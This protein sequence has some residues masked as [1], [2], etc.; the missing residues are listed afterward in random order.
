MA[1]V[2]FCYVSQDKELAHELASALQKMGLETVDAVLRLGDS[3]SQ[4]VEQGLRDADY[5]VI[6]LS[7]AFF[8]KPW[9]RQELD[10]LTRIEREYEGHTQL[11][12]IWHE[13]AQQDIARFSPTLASKVG[14][15]TSH[16]VA[17]VAEE[18]ADV[19]RAKQSSASSGMTKGYPSPPITKGG[20]MT[21]AAGVDLK[22]LLQILQENFSE[23]ELRL[24]CFELAIDYEDLPGSGKKRKSLE[25]ISY[26]Q[27]HAKL[28][29]L[30]QAINVQRP[31][32][33][34]RW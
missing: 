9:P 28:D 32:L 6:I 16:G 26:A 21:G 27:R 25:L 22:Q 8:R 29:N 10:K 17:V 12:P 2:F 15:V 7:H 13:I 11:L 33:S 23:D 1:N 30:V 19:V 3:L 18:I 20:P 4:R 24:L 14:A 34:L 5:G 31:H